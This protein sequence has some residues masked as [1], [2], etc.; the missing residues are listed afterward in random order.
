LQHAGITVYLAYD[1]D[2]VLVYRYCTDPAQRDTFDVRDITLPPV[3]L[4]S[5]LAIAARIQRAI[6][7]G[8]LTQEGLREEDE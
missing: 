6:D 7:A 1:D 2:K 8:L 4:D 5:M 3:T